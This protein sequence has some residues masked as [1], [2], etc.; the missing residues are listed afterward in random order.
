MFARFT[1]YRITDHIGF[2]VVG[3]RRIT[4]CGVAAVGVASVGSSIGSSS[5]SS[6]DY[7]LW[8]HGFAGITDC[9]R[10]SCWYVLQDDG[11]V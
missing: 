5:R 7:G 10:I 9:V 2:N 4:D 1:D 8:D 11:L 6:A 3:Q